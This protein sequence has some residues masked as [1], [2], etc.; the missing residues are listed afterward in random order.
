MCFVLN[1]LI[2]KRLI[3]TNFQFLT[4]KIGND[5]GEGSEIGEDCEIGELDPKKVV[6]KENRFN[7]DSDDEDEYKDGKDNA[8]MVN[9][10]YYSNSTSATSTAAD[11][12]DH[13]YGKY[14][15]KTISDALK[16]EIAVI[17]D[18]IMEIDSVEWNRE[19]N[20]VSKELDELNRKLEEGDTMT[21]MQGKASSLNLL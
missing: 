2:N 14:S 17:E 11:Q 8:Q 7:V 5:D 15:K 9:T 20:R 3:L 10:T 18:G 13:L 6:K 12:N 1:E 4:P 16:D 19:V 21:L